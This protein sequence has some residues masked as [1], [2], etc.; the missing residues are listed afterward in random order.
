MIT[1]LLGYLEATALSRLIRE[2]GALFPWLEVIHVVA[3]CTVLGTILVVD[4]RLLGLA[5]RELP[6]SVL[7]RRMLPLTW[8]GFLL[9]AGSGALLFLSQPLAYY[10]NISF[11][12]KI[13]M[14]L[15]AAANMAVFHLA[16]QR[17]MQRW[18]LDASPPLA[19][20]IAGLFSIACWIVVVCAARW[21]GFTLT[22]F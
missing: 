11:R 16:T 19:A 17:D 1:K 20:R 9:A 6:V 21:I 10:N 8:V 18:D 3:I 13:L 2:N 4:L 7:N 22:R 5:T 15:L 14:L 12:L